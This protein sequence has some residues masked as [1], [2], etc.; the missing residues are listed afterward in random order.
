VFIEL[1]EN[2]RKYLFVF[3]R[4]GDGGGWFVSF[5]SMRERPY[6]STLSCERKPPLRKNMFNFRN[7]AI[8]IVGKSF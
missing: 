1:L 7:R 4:E 3:W 2:F 8:F 6:R 5:M